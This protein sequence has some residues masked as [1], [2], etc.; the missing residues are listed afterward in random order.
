M[1]FPGVYF[2]E[3]ESFRMEKSGVRKQ[4]PSVCLGVGQE[5]DSLWVVVLFFF[6][7][8]F[9]NVFILFLM[10]TLHLIAIFCR[11]RIPLRLSSQ[12]VGSYLTWMLGTKLRFSA[13]LTS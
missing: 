13:L 5:R 10:G 6:L 11:G 7:R 1:S 9:K 2:K 3:G 4:Q 12:A 8:N